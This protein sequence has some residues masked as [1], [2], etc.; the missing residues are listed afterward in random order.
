MDSHDD[1][2][3]KQL[4]IALPDGYGVRR[5]EIDM[6]KRVVSAL[7]LAG[8]VAVAMSGPFDVSAAGGQHP[9]TVHEWGT[10]TTVAG[11][12]GQAEEWLPLSGPSDL[13]CFVETFRNGLFKY[14]P[15]SPT[16]GY[17]PL[18]DY[19]TARTAL[20][21][22][23]RMETP[24]LYFYTGHQT[25][26]AVNVSFPNGLFTEWY[27][28]ATVA[29]AP[30]WAHVLRAAAAPAAQIG[31]RHVSV[32]PNTR[33]I[34][35][36][37]DSPSHYYAARNTDAAPIHV[38]G[39]DEKFL[40]YRG[41]GG[42]A[43]P[44]AVSVNGPRMLTVRTVGNDPLPAVVIFANH[45]GRIGY[46][47]HRGPGADLTIDRPPL[48]ALGESKANLGAL[49]RELS[50][51]LTAEGLYKKEADAMVDT[52]RDT[53]FEEGTRIL[54]IVPKPAVE[55]I[56]RLNIKPQ[57]AAT[58]RVFVGRMDVITDEEVQDV[59][60][61]IAR[62]DRAAL[63]RHGRLLGV[64]GERILKTE[65][66]IPERKRIEAVLDRAFKAFAETAAGCD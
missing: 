23:V 7:V 64:L 55:A 34:F 18:L 45:G 65:P 46:R 2:N 53:W 60:A 20:R 21:G 30:S 51:L 17:G 39:Q 50:S 16:A 58:S 59:R 44:V 43:V 26:L 41:V 5:E 4:L 62:D 49:R 28:K 36:A 61:A 47:V 48:H 3:N 52:W 33:P 66:S 24:V 37:T 42:F 12:D 35:P 56:L 8:A 15:G 22:T 63:A 6:S 1:C 57:A 14:L 40:F 32:R 31:W 11:K 54:Y 9:F 27:P 25:D 10:F 13:P 29:Q 19:R 38:D